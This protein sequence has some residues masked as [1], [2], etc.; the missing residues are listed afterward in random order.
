MSVHLIKTIEQYRCDTEAEAKNFIEEQKTSKTYEMGKYATEMR[1]RKQ[2][3]EIVDEW[4]RV[5]LTKIFD[6][7]AEPITDIKNIR[8]GDRDDS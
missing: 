6:E 3:G 4:F 1:V 7:E 5:T 2:K 8:Y